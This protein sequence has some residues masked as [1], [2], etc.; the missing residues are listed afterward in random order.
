M[1]F[2][3]CPGARGVIICDWAV[4]EGTK[5]APDP[6]WNFPLAIAAWKMFPALVAGNTVVWKPASD[7]PAMAYETE[8][9]LC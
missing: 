1:A 7:T 3:P 4:A 8:S 9:E 6:H 2:G 5:R